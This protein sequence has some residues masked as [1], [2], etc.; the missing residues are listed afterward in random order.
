[1]TGLVAAPGLCFKLC[2]GHQ[3]ANETKR[4]VHWTQAEIKRLHKQT[5]EAQ[6]RMDQERQVGPNMRAVER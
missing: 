2:R 3:L 6:S 5:E 4:L 1:M